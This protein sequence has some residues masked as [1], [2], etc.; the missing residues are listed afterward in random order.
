MLVVDIEDLQ[1][2]WYQLRYQPANGSG[3]YHY[4]DTTPHRKRESPLLPYRDCCPTRTTPSRLLHLARTINQIVDGGWS[5][6]SPWSACNVTCGAG[7][8]TRDRTCTNPA[9]ANFGAD[10][11]GL[12]EE[13]QPCDAGP[14]P[15]DGGW[16]DWG[17]WTGCSVT[18]GVGTETRER[19]CN[20]PAPA[21]GGA[22]CVGLG[23]ETQQCNAGPC[24][25][26]GGWSDWGAWSACSV[27]CGNGTET[28]ERTCNNPAPAN[29]G[30]GCVGETHDTR[31]CNT[32]MFCSGNSGYTCTCI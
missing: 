2:S 29:G 31:A 7:T 28:R 30:A 14:C 9:P 6:W 24:P 12:G 20:N 15:V 4:Q 13:T 1:I 19:T 16:S 23:E 26:D 32:G 8:Q 11:V 3:S 5:D 25:V 10:C 27:T 22:G 17:A 18:C 21:N